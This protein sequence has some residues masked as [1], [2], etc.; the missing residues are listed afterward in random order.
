VHLREAAHDTSPGRDPSRVR[1][2]AQVVEDGRLD[3][4]AAFPSGLDPDVVVAAFPALLA[5]HLARGGSAGYV[6]RR[7]G[8]AAVLAATST[9]TAPGGVLRREDLVQ[10]ILSEH[11]RDALPFL[12]ILGADEDAAR[13][14][15]V[16]GAM[17]RTDI[18]CGAAIALRV[19]TDARLP[20]SLLRVLCEDGFVGVD[21]HREDPIAVAE[22]AAVAEARIPTVDVEARSYAT[23][24]LGG[25]QRRLVRPVVDRL[26]ARRLLVFFASPRAVRRA[27]SGVLARWRDEDR[28]AAEAA[29]TTRA[30][31]SRAPREE[32]R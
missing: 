22:I 24:A 4:D 16:I 31:I 1:L 6:A 25:L 8:R 18:P 15:A 20:L 26:L 32:A 17:R 7:V 13:H 21:S 27:A 11:T 3:L 29:A 19:A 5:T 23:I 12:E 9:L 14:K 30:T 28:E 2:L 10:K